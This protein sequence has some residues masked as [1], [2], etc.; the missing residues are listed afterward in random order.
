LKFIPSIY[1][2]DNKPITLVASYTT[3]KSGVKTFV[4][5]ISIAQSTLSMYETPN[6]VLKLSAYGK[7]NS[8]E[9][10]KTWVDTV[11]N[12]NTTFTN[13]ISFDDNLGWYNNGFRVSGIGN[14]ATINYNPLA[15]N[16]SNGR[17]IEFEFQTEKVN[18]T[19]DV[20]MMFGDATGGHI[21]IT[22][23]SAT[24]YDSSNN[25][26]LH[27]NFK[28]NERLKLAFIINNSS[29]SD[30]S[31]LIYIVN[32]GIL[33]RAI[34]AKGIIFTNNTGKITIGNSESG[35]ILYNIRV[36]NRAISY[37]DAYNNYVYDSEN[38]ST[39]IANN[40]VLLNGEINFD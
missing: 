8:S 7:T 32:N 25:D 22:P 37:T 31:D 19:N 10:A 4:I 14:Y 34:N 13:S 23:N 17:T 15:G 35:I 29:T 30:E 24:I 3:S 18:N 11:H 1:T 2:T 16:P 26:I 6:Y 28:S 27:T 39:I 20:I 9:D 38:K 12:I 5:P 36:Y 33:E 21:S 40:D